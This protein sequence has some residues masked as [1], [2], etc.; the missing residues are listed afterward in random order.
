MLLSTLYIFAYFGKYFDNIC[1][2]VKYYCRIMGSYVVGRYLFL[3]TLYVF[4]YFGKYFN[5]SLTLIKYYCKNMDTLY[6]FAYFGKYFG[7]QYFDDF[8]NGFKYYSSIIGSYCVGRYLF[9][10]LTRTY[11][12]IWVKYFLKEMRHNSASLI[13]GSK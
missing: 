9:L 8:F 6:V 3:S 7:S 4:L 10:Y 11:L 12:H 2:G 5:N 13:I 1:T